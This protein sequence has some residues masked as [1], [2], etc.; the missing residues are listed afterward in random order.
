MF[1]T[2]KGFLFDTLKTPNDWLTITQS[3]S[4]WLSVQFSY[5]RF[6]NH[7]KKFVLIYAMIFNGHQCQIFRR[8]SV[9]DAPQSTPSQIQGRAYNRFRKKNKK[10]LK[11]FKD[12]A[13]ANFMA[14]M[15]RSN[16]LLNEGYKLY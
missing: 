9:L 11:A 10:T 12:A 7:F 5:Y 2:K 8:N 15:Q 4:D 16:D 6:G 13:F 3:L 1:Q 14:S